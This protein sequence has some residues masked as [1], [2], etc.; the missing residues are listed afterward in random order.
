MGKLR[1]GNFARGYDIVLYL[2]EDNSHTLSGAAKE[3]NINIT[4]ARSD[5]YQVYLDAKANRCIEPE[6]TLKK[7]AKVYARLHPECVYNN[8]G[9][10][11]RG[12]K[13]IRYL[14]KNEQLTLE[15][16]AKDL[17]MSVTRAR[18]DFMKV[19]TDAREGRC[20]EPEKKLK[21]FIKVF[22][23]LYPDKVIRRKK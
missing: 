2:L 10:F 16:A 15:D 8:S 7:F 6:E 17:E 18:A 1:G 23:R 4:T 21:M 20:A 19:Y 13:L 22:S 3:K 9:N 11:A 5:F 14:L 12:Y